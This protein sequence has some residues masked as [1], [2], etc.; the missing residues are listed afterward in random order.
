LIQSV[1]RDLRYALAILAEIEGKRPGSR[2][3]PRGE[4]NEFQ[5]R[6]QRNLAEITEKL[7]RLRHD[8]L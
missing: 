2:K 1:I 5:Q 7:N 3:E 6:I 4:L 8:P